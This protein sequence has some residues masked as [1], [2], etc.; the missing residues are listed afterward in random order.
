MCSSLVSESSLSLSL[1][2]SKWNATDAEVTFPGN[3]E[4]REKVSAK[5]PRSNIDPLFRGLIF[6]IA[7]FELLVR[8]DGKFGGIINLQAVA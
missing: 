8:F 1:S 4:R 5:A 2:S 7:T 6:L 3:V